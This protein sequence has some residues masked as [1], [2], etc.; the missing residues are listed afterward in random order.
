MHKGEHGKDGSRHRMWSA[1]GV[2]KPAPRSTKTTI[3]I[4]HVNPIMQAAPSQ[5]RIIS[6]IEASNHLLFHS[7]KLFFVEWI[8]WRINIFLKSC[9]RSKKLQPGG[10]PNSFAF[11]NPGRPRRLINCSQLWSQQSP[12]KPYP[13]RGDSRRSSGQ[14]R[15]RSASDGC[16]K[17][18]WETWSCWQCGCIHP[19]L[20][21]YSSSAL[22]VSV[23]IFGWWDAAHRFLPV[24][25][26]NFYDR[27][28]S[29]YSYFHDNI[30]KRCP[31]PPAKHYI[32]YSLLACH[33]I[34]ILASLPASC[35]GPLSGDW[36]LLRSLTWKVLLLWASCYNWWWSPLF[37]SVCWYEQGTPT[38]PAIIMLRA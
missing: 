6:I 15:R 19:Q 2:P 16:R 22:I 30:S 12:N 1:C 3:M 9:S 23:G 29:V 33:I 4:V 14:T 37:W 27:T 17:G 11:R 36:N 26:I 21:W 7:Q 24:Y 10:K 38:Y 34:M 18:R 35:F 20:S 8:W 31:P 13:R 32:Q 25:I 28:T 5:R